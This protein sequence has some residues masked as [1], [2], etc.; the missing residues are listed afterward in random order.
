[1]IHSHFLVENVTGALNW[2]SSQNSDEDCQNRKSSGCHRKIEISP[3]ATWKLQR[4][5]P[6]SD[7]IEISA[8]KLR[9]AAHRPERIRKTWN[10]S[11]HCDVIARRLPLDSSFAPLRGVCIRLDNDT[12]AP[13]CHW[14]GSCMRERYF[15]DRKRFL[16]HTWMEKFRPNFVFLSHSRHFSTAAKNTHFRSF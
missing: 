6:S 7:C 16:T 1:M 8:D 10:A 5:F 15:Q 14:S 13:E 9:L 3:A 11:L 2:T 4:I 12:N